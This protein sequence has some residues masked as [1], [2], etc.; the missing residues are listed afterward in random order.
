MPQDCPKSIYYGAL[1]A[2]LREGGQVVLDD[3]S[4]REGWI[5]NEHRECFIKGDLWFGD[6]RVAH[7]PCLT[8]AEFDDAVAR[9]L[10]A[11]EKA[12]AVLDAEQERHDSL[13]GAARERL[14]EVRAAYEKAIR[15]NQRR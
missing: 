2:R 3:E 10:P 1:T 14:P 6:K 8:Q 13:Y 12:K 9:S 15:D 5:L 7:K 4:F 11:Y